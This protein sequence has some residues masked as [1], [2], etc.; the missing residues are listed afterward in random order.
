MS[1]GDFDGKIGRIREKLAE[2]G[3]QPREQLDDGR[4]RVNFSGNRNIFATNVIYHF[5]ARSEETVRTCQG[6]QGVDWSVAPRLARW[7]AVDRHGQAHWFCAP[8]VAAFTDFWYSESVVA[9]AFGFSG[10][11]R[12]SLTERPLSGRG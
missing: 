4:Q 10:D 3:P 1:A 5:A 9:P 7:W 2:S 12:E 6:H 11:W 8:N